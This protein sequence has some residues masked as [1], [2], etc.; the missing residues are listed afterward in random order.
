MPDLVV[1]NCWPSHD[2]PVP[3]QVDLVVE[4]W[5]PEDTPEDR[6]HRQF[7][8]ATAGIRYF[9]AVE[10]DGPVVTPYELR[11][12]SYREQTTLCPGTVGT[13]TAAP[14]PVTFDPGQFLNWREPRVGLSRPEPESRP[15]G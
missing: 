9:W 4:V 14:V 6:R 13:I 15:A 11:D 7:S 3:E 10:Q 1:L 8:Y 12:G 5:S 2:Y